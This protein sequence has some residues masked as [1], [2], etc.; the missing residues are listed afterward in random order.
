MR[1]CSV[2]GCNKK[3]YGKGLCDK[4]YRSMWWKKNTS[5]AKIYRSMHY[6]VHR[7]RILANKSKWRKEHIKEARRLDAIQREKYKERRRLYKSQ[8]DKDNAK[9]IRQYHKI[10]G[11]WRYK[12]DICFRLSNILRSRL[13]HAIRSSIDGSK[14]VSSI[15]DLGCTI[16]EFKMYLERKFLPGMTWSNYGNQLGMWSM[17]HTIPLSSV[18]LSKRKESLSI[19]HYANIRPMW[20]IENM[21]KGATI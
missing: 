20:H 4:H 15:K 10:H 18:D 16:P 3:Y 21:K 6:V 11:K 13:S 9:K 12:N 8:W 2:D 7:G 5:K 19:V 1:L 14:V 17:D